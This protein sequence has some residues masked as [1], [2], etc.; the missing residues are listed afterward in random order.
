MG[1]L[2]VPTPIDVVEALLFASDVPL[3]AERI[4]E[5][6][7]LGDVGEAR[8]LVDELRARYDASSQGLQ[9]VEVGGGYRMV[10]RPDVA[11]WLVRLARARTRARLSRPALEALAIVAYKQPV[12]RPEIDAVR[13][14][15]SDAVLENLL[16][17]RLVRITGRKEAPGRPYLFETTR[18]F[19]VAFGLRDVADLPKVEGELIVPELAAVAEHGQAETQ[20]DPGAGGADVTT[21]G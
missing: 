18:E 5:V 6:L 11:P 19:L 15:N 14:V 2:P 4:R 21:G 20:Q 1:R 9:I 3:E 17:R 7:D 16:E 10:T 12:S 13:G 8:A